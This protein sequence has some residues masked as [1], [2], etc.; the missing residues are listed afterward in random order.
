MLD[1]STQQREDGAQQPGVFFMM[2][3]HNPSTF[4]DTPLTDPSLAL[5]QQHLLIALD[6]A[7]EAMLLSS[8][9]RLILHW[10]LGLL[11]EG[12]Q[13]FEAIA[14]RLGISPERVRQLQNQAMRRLQKNPD[15]FQALDAYLHAQPL[16][17]ERHRNV[18]WLTHERTLAP[19]RSRR[20]S[21]QHKVRAF[22][23]GKEP[24]AHVCRHNKNGNK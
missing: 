22:L 8:R 2:T 19:L 13:T 12:Y 3:E 11:S 14:A 10:R 20:A 1:P 23:E 6:Q 7:V 5:S 18:P 15:T 9:E 16:P 24:P 4:V 17:P 21:R